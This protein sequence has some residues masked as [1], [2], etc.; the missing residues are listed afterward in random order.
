MWP[1]AAPITVSSEPAAETR[2]RGT[3]DQPVDGVV[4]AGRVVMEERQLRHAG[5][6]AG[7]DDV[8]DGAVAPPD[9]VGV[10]LGKVL[11]VVNHEIGI[12]QKPRMLHVAATCRQVSAPAE[13]TIVRLVIARIDHTRTVDL[14]AIAE[15]QRR[16]VEV[17]GDD[18]RVLDRQLSFDEIVIVDVGTEL[19]DRDREVRVLHLSGKR[20]GQGVAETPRAVDVPVVVG[21]EHRGEERKPLDV[22]PVGVAD[23]QVSVD[24]LTFGPLAEI[25]TQPVRTRTAVDDEQGSCIGADL[26]T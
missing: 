5:P 2:A 15:R 12:R 3:L 8:F 26:D 10:L 4:V 1:S 22:V 17:L 18:G 24:R 11:G 25:E 7:V 23:Q 20:L 6:H 9:L 16:V 21:P 19:I 14:E 13:F